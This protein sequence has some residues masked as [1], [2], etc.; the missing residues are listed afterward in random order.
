MENEAGE[1][2]VETGRLGGYIRELVAKGGRCCGF[3]V[4]S[5]LREQGGR[6][7]CERGVE[8]WGIW[9]DL[10]RPAS[11]MVCIRIGMTNIPPL[12]FPSL[13]FPGRTIFSLPFHSLP[14]FPLLLFLLFPR[15][16]SHF[17][18]TLEKK[19]DAIYSHPSA[20]RT[21]PLIS[22]RCLLPWSGFDSAENRGIPHSIGLPGEGGGESG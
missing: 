17:S 7:R 4:L 18:T 9:C 6:W 8:E 5:L 12:P 3:W 11:Q 10:S 21:G 2:R 20:E 14:F 1:W 13:S 15:T 19:N 22:T 16:L